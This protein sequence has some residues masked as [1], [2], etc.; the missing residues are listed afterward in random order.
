MRFEIRAYASGSITS[1]I[2]EAASREDAL[3]QV[4]SQSLHPIGVQELV[5]PQGYVRGQP[6]GRFE[7]LLFTQELLALLEAGL[8]IIEAIETLSAREKHGAARNILDQLA[9]RLREGKS[10]ASAL[11]TLPAVFTSLFVGLVRSAERT[12]NLQA[13]LSRYVEYRQRV[14]GLRSKVINAA[15]YPSL[16]I[17]VAI[18]VALFLG[19]YVVPRFAAVYQGAG[20]QLPWA[21][22]LLLLWGNFARTHAA[23]LLGSA[24]LLCMGIAWGARNLSRR[25]GISV[26][27]GK[28]PIFAEQAK[29][30]EISR[31]FLTLGMLLDSGLPVVPALALAEEALSLHL[32]GPLRQ[33]GELIRTGEKLSVAFERVGLTTAVGLRMLQVGEESGR[34]GE[35]MARAARFH[36]EETGRWIERFSRVAEPTLMVGIGLVIGTIVVLL[37]MPI[38]DL[39]GSLR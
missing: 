27:I 25:G 4:A 3:Q 31:L 30:Y 37:Y 2:V 26:L 16:L 6:G 32:R 15:I 17:I 39:A 13:A 20:R 28:I 34:L 8:S 9:V 18:G 22:E 19:G 12:G 21:S 29:T 24:A 33:A 14:D 11:E 5:G 10:L 1:R 36:D 7:A 38:F 35:M 23:S